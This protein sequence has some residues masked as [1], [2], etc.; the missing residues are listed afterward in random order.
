MLEAAQASRLPGRWA[1]K[2]PALPALPTFEIQPLPCGAAMVPVSVAKAHCRLQGSH[3]AVFKIGSMD[4]S[5]F[6]T[7]VPI[8]LVIGRNRGAVQPRVTREVTVNIDTLIT[9]I[10]AERERQIADP[11]SN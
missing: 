10:L 2:M 4:R 5:R 11:I 8:N 3:D 1:G 7:A 6:A 9:W